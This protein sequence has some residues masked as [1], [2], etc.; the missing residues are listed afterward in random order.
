MA[1]DDARGAK[2]ERTRLSRLEDGTA[3]AEAALSAA[4]ADLGAAHAA[5]QHTQSLARE[6]EQR[7]ADQRALL[8]VALGQRDEAGAAIRELGERVDRERRQAL[9][10][11]Q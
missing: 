7:L 5:L 10:E 9:R 2:A 8:A 6:Q 11:V 4:R 1:Q 3:K